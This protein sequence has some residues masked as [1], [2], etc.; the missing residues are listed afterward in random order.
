MLQLS[1][2]KPCHEDWNGMQPADQ[3]RHCNACAK[4]VIDFTSMSD[5][6]VK[7]FLLS[8]A[9][10]RVC[11]RFNSDQLHRINISLPEDIFE[12]RLPWWKHF[13][14]ASLVAFSMLMFSC[15][16]TVNGEPLLSN[17][18]TDSV[19]K[20]KPSVRHTL[21]RIVP[22]KKITDSIPPKCTV[23][24]DVAV[25]PAPV[26]PIMGAVAQP[27][28]PPKEKPVIMGKLKPPANRNKKS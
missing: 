23:K 19:P 8:K 5:D 15:T 24:G 1:I 25:D 22:P 3:G 7:N 14:A 9:D 18:I 11:G 21:G 17:A 6:E 12:Y 16:T 10:E 20:P 4:T 27:V 13:L 28:P 2:P 26:Y